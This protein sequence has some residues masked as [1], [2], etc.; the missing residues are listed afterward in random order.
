M[1]MSLWD[2][3]AAHMLWLDS[4]YPLDRD[5]SK[6]GVAR[7]PCAKD[8]GAPDDV[9][10]KH[11]DATV[12]FSNIRYGPLGS[13]YPV[14]PTPAPAPTPPAPPAPTGQCTG[15]GYACH[16]SC[17]SCGRCN[18]KPGCQSESQCMGT[19]N[20]GNNAMWCGGGSAPTPA[21]PS[22]TPA[23]PAPSEWVTHGCAWRAGCCCVMRRHLLT[24]RI[25]AEPRA[26]RRRGRQTLLDA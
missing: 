16:G 4:D 7:G 15:C 18:M 11:P 6:A 10:A 19:C 25:R 24:W 1:V 21:P 14:A 23:P 22:P 9:R 12:A 8:S 20:S 26:T 17:S 3:G 2:D 13:T 5:T